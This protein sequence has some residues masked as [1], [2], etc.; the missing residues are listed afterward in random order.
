MVA[1]SEESRQAIIDATLT[2]MGLGDEK[3]GTTVQRL[4]IESIAKR[5]GVSKATIY[6]WWPN[7][8]AV[9][10]DAFVSDYL[11]H[12]PIDPDLPADEALA[13]HVKSVVR[14]YAGDDG[15]IIA[16][17]IAEG[18]YDKDV[19]D[20]FHERFWDDRARVV[21]ALMQRGVEEGVLR[22]DLDLNIAASIIYAPIYQRLL[23]GGGPLDDAFVDDLLA[24]A[25]RSL[26]PP[27]SK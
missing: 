10:L 22:D 17:I 11:G 4:T 16:Q 25:F 2:L 18:Q 27:T 20:A 7:K 1:R 23:L 19:L 5:A 21:L 8:V 24:L 13:A 6:R 26:R 12:T 15:R 3:P 14:Q 9:V